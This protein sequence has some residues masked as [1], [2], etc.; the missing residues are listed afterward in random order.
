MKRIA[1]IG[2]GGIGSFFIREWSQLNVS[3]VEGTK[4]TLT[5]IYDADDV[6]EKNLRYQAF[7]LEDI[8]SPKSQVLGLRYNFGNKVEYITTE[9]QLDEFDI[10]VIA[11]DNGKLRKLVYEYC[12]KN[13]KKYF[14]DMRSE[15][16]AICAYTSHPTNTLEKLLKTINAEAPATSCQLKFELNSGKIQVGNRII[17]MIGIQMLLNKLRNEDNLPEFSF[18][19]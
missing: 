17:A 14:I 8:L 7:E 5:T 9:E 12:D 6:E 3:G 11:V 1:I 2:C 18:R 19:F 10:F 13:P 16:R 4:D 15:S